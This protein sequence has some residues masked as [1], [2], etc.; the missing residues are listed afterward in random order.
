MIKNKL[1]NLLLA[2]SVLIFSFTNNVFAAPASNTITASGTVTATCSVTA[3]NIAFGEL[4]NDGTTAAAATTFTPN[5]SNGTGWTITNAGNNN[6]LYLD[7]NASYTGTSRI[8]FPIVLTGTSTAFTLANAATGKLT[9]TGTGSA[10]VHGSTVTGTAASG[11]GKVYGT[12][13]GTV[14]LTITY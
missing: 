4:S 9:G 6:Y 1:K 3:S 8:E 10:N 7:S 2:Y 11:A 5:C 14:T 13:G 12:Y